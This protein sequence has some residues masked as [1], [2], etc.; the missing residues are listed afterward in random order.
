M[1]ITPITHVFHAYRDYLD[2]LYGI[3]VRAIC[4][5][6]DF[7]LVQL[8]WTRERQREY[9]IVAHIVIRDNKVWVEYNSAEF[10][11][12]ELLEAGI[13]PNDIIL[14]FLPANDQ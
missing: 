3:E 2:N 11:V 8:G 12:R 1:D 7:L 4:T 13:S 10:L 5:P 6:T 14:G 9:S